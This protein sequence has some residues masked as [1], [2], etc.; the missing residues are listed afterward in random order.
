[1]LSPLAQKRL[2]D[3]VGKFLGKADRAVKELVVS[4][5]F[6]PPV[7][8]ACSALN[9]VYTRNEDDVQ[10]EV[11]YTAGLG[12][13]RPNEVFDP[14]AEMQAALVKGINSR[15]GGMLSKYQMSCSAWT[16][17]YFKSRFETQSSLNQQ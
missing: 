6:V 11:G 15:V 14:T 3:E 13:Y 12:I 4:L 8:V 2:G 1:M 5:W 17:P 10:V 16:K 7:D 9:L